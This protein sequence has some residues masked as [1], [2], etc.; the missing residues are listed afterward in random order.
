MEVNVIKQACIVAA[1]MGSRFGERSKALPKPLFRMCGVSILERV[2]LTCRKCG[3]RDFVIVIGYMGDTIRDYIESVKPADIRVEWVQNSEWKKKNGVSVL[4]AR[5]KLQ[6]RF[7]LLMSDHIFSSELLKE[8]L[9]TDDGRDVH[10]AVDPRLDRV[11]DMEDTTRVAYG[12]AGIQAIGKELTDFNGADTGIFVGNSDFIKALETAYEKHEQDCSISEGCRELIVENKFF[13]IEVHHGFWQDVDDESCFKEARKRLL[14]S[15]RKETDGVLAA[16]I[17]RRISIAI[18][19]RLC[20]FPIHPNLMTIANFFIGVAAAVFFAIPGYGTGVAGALLFQASSI[21]DGCDGET[22]RLKFTESKLGGWLDLILDNVVHV[23]IFSAIGSRIYQ[24]TNPSE[25]LI[26]GCLMV[27]GVVVS[28]VLVSN[29]CVKGGKLGALKT[30]RGDSAV[31]K[32]VNYLARRDFTYLL[33]LLSLFGEI[34]M[35]IFAWMAAVGSNVFALT[36]F[37]LFYFR[38]RSMVD[39]SQ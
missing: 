19:S 23:L 13:A 18:S 11:F 9:E 32:L 30:G 14:N 39:S 37:F 17:N 15:L 25:A 33:L 10:L 7:L 34:G 2:I 4:S 27:A 6:D 22:A 28:M 3:I 38:K 1:G 21:L 26:L 24:T 31:L 35:R 29:A 36:V 20:H 5:D 8:V 12:E 16:L